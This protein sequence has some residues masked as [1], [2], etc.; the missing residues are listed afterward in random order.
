VGLSIQ[1]TWE[2]GSNKDHNYPAQS[3]KSDKWWKVIGGPTRKDLRKG[4]TE[5][6]RP[7]ATTPDAI[8]NCKELIQ[9]R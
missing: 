8:S 9:K 3:S 4:T 2:T 7:V 5:R 1:L 6:K